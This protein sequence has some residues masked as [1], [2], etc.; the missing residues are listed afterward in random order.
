MQLFAN[1]KETRFFLTDDHVKNLH[2]IQVASISDVLS[3]G[4]ASIA[5]LLRYQF[6]DIDDIDELVETTDMQADEFAHLSN[7]KRL[8]FDFLEHLSFAEVV[9]EAVKAQNNFDEKDRLIRNIE[10]L[11]NAELRYPDNGKTI[12]FATPDQST[13]VVDINHKRQTIEINPKTYGDI[14]QEPSSSGDIEPQIL[15]YIDPRELF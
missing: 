4:V 12:C 7:K 14:T 13:L 10:Y 8:T 9:I 15:S 1:S 5:A 11:C 6:I 3:K 2:T